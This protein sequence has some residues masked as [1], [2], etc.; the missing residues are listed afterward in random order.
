MSRMTWPVRYS[1]VLHRPRFVTLIAALLVFVAAAL[2][3]CAPAT[4]SSGGAAILAPAARTEPSPGPTA[5]AAPAATSTAAIAAVAADWQQQGEASWYGLKFAGRRT[6]SGEIFDPSQLT[7]AHRT[8]PFGTRLRVSDLATGR[9]VVVRVNDRGPF[10]HGRIIDLS[11]AAAERIGLVASG[12]TQVR[13]TLAGGPEGLR[14]L[15]VDSRLNGYDVIV[16]GADPGA[17]LVLS[18][19]SGVEVIVRAVDLEPV[20][21]SRSDGTDIWTSA[22]LAERLGTVATATVESF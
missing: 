6:A 20:A 1:T 3:A 16:P 21:S 18:S 9:S 22:S 12:V 5:S 7:A 14:P 15:R 17:L 19:E 13:L 4:T 10:A 11:R 2:T 8:L